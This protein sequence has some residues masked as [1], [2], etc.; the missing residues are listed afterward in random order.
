[1]K[2][3][4]LCPPN[5]NKNELFELQ[6]LC[7]HHRVKHLYFFGSILTPDF[8]AD[9]DIDLLVSFEEMDILD[10]ADN[11]FAFLEAL[12]KFFKR[13]VDLVIEKNISNPI[14]LESI[15]SIRQLAYEKEDTEVVA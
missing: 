2:K 7:G 4:S 5:I 11:Y 12:Q 14:L 6:E 9:S 1:M 10:Y 3:E 15:L 13:E 8:H